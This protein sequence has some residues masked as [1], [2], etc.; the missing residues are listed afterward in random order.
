[1][2]ASR[3]EY[4]VL[5]SL[6]PTASPALVSFQGPRGALERAKD[7]QRKESKPSCPGRPCRDPDASQVLMIANTRRR[8][9]RWSSTGRER[10]RDVHHRRKATMDQMPSTTMKGHVFAS[11]P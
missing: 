1:V 9:Y 10:L 11:A 3:L 5:R 8:G 4:I 6:A 2:L 7:R